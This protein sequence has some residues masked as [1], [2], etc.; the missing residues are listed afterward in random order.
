MCRIKA[1]ETNDA[2]VLKFPKL[3]V[4]LRTPINFET[5]KQ[6]WVKLSKR[7]CGSLSLEGVHQSLPSPDRQSHEE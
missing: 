3:N 5:K 6:T 4:N 1:D 2:K 7:G